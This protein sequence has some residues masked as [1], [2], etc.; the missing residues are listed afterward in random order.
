MIEVLNRLNI[1]PEEFSNAYIEKHNIN[2]NRD[3][4]RDNK[5]KYN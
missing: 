5:K 3:Y 1:S 2:M 4:E